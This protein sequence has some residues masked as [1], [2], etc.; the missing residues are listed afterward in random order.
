MEVELDVSNG[1]GQVESDN[2]TD[3]V[4][5]GHD[6]GHGQDLARVVLHAGQEHDRQ[7]VTVLGNGRQDVLGPQDLDREVV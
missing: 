3:I 5:G 7:F 6:V 1:V 4:P 2:R